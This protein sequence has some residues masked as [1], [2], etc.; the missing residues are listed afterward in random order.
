MQWFHVTALFMNSVSWHYLRKVLSYMVMADTQC[1]GMKNTVQWFSHAETWATG[2][3]AAIVSSYA[4][5][6]EEVVTSV[7]DFQQSCMHKHKLL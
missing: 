4:G 2:M 1:F 7:C 3:P 5:A 6:T